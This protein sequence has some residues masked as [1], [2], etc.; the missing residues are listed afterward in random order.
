VGFLLD[1][2]LASESTVFSGLVKQLYNYLE[3]EAASNSEFS[4]YKAD[5]PRWTE[6]P[7][8]R[9][10][11]IPVDWT[12]PGDYDDAKSLAFDLYASCAEQPGGGRGLL[13]LLYGS[14]DPNENLRE[15]NDAFGPF[16]RQAVLDILAAQKPITP[17][18]VDSRSQGQV[19]ASKVERDVSELLKRPA[20]PDAQR[21]TPVTGAYVDTALGLVVF[22]TE[23]ATGSEVSLKPRSPEYD[24]ALSFAGEDRPYVEQVAEQLTARGIKVF[25]D[26][27]EKADLWGKDLYTH[28]SDVYQNKALYTLMFISEHYK[29]KV[30]PRH[31]RA[32]AQARALEEGREYILPARFDDTDIPGLL[33]TTKFVDLRSV[34]PVE[35]A[36]LVCEK[37]GRDPLAKKAYDLPSPQNRALSGEG[38]FDYSSYNGRFRIGSG[39]FEFETCWT[40]A[41]DRTIYCYADSPSVRAVA[42]APKGAGITDIRDASKLDFT[43]RTRTPEVGRAMVLQNHHG[44][45]AALQILDIKDDSRGAE[46]DSLHFRYRILTDG[47]DNFSAVEEEET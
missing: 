36:L 43:S 2:V 9:L 38:S 27:Y 8:P 31:E 32:A 24:V 35:V 20:S 4:R 23:N 17:T 33:P 34:K 37:L 13:M 41:S 25:Y 3:K 45:Y 14:T 7:M 29:G 47:S 10:N 19:R 12:M 16:L 6:W 40:K 22:E 26:N 28:L 11:S 39:Q 5:R 46:H 30:W 21:L 42:L 44:I 1:Q 18:P 15:F